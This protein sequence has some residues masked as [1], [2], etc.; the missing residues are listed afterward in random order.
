MSFFFAKAYSYAIGTWGKQ[1][2]VMNHLEEIGFFFG[3]K[4]YLAPK[5]QLEWRKWKV[6]STNKAFIYFL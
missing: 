5:L 3:K 1:V 4:I 2:C 6:R